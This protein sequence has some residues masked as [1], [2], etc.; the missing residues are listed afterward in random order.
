MPS[1]SMPVRVRAVDHDLVAGVSAVQVAAVAALVDNVV[2]LAAGGP[3][4]RL[5]GDSPDLVP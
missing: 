3:T 4:L 5:G 2:V 1:P